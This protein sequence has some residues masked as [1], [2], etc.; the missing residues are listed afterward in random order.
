MGKSFESMGIAYETPY[1]STVCKI[2][3]RV[4]EMHYT[5]MYAMGCQARNAMVRLHVKAS[6]GLDSTTCTKSELVAST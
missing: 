6:M 3:L 4:S 1:N 2:Y 5:A